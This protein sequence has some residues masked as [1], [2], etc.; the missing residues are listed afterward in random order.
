MN[1]GKHAGFGIITTWVHIL[2]LAL[3]SLLT[4]DALPNVFESRHLCL[5]N[6]DEEIS[7]AGMW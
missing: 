4:V 7:L 3:M 2:P 1:N 5:L 6:G